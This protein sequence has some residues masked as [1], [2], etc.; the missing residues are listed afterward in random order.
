[1]PPHVA[2]H[3][4]V[5]Q[6]V[7]LDLDLPV[8]RARLAAAAATLEREP[9]RLVAPRPRLGVRDMSSRMGLKTFV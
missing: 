4:D 5:G 3:V 7:H 1:L 2:G 9:A 6:E 8:A